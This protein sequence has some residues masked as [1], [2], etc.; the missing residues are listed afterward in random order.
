MRKN[1]LIEKPIPKLLKELAIPAI[2]GVLFNTLYNVVDTFY[3]GLISTEAVAGLSI[4]FFLYFAVVGVGFGFGAAITALIGNSLG[5]KRVFLGSLYAHKG[6]VFVLLLGSILAVLGYI[7]AP[8]VLKSVGAEDNYLPLALEYIRIILFATPFFTA[9]NALN[10]ILVALGDTK[11]YRNMLIVGFF[12]NLILNPLF[13]YGFWILPSLGIKGLALS[14]ALIQVISV[15]YLGKR[16]LNEKMLCFTKVRRYL[17][18]WRIYKH[19]LIQGIPPSMNML[20]MSLGSVITIYYVAIYGYEAVAGYGI[21]FRVEQIM[22]LP[23][24]GLSSAVLSLV[25]NNFGAKLNSRVKETVKLALLVGFLI[26]VIGI[27]LT[28]SI[29]EW[30]ISKFDSNE[31]VIQRAMEYLRI[32]VFAFFGYVVLFISVSALQGIKKP[33]M[34]LYVG[35]YRQI[36][37]KIIIFSLFVFWFKLPYIWLWY[38]LF[39]IIFSS[40]LFL[41]RHTYKALSS[42]K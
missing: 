34:I 4:S 1:E 5:K 32:E 37:G 35:L 41:G 27:F 14:T 18:D 39:F 17:P 20:T 23:A 2:T 29:G 7:F 6:I 12:L 10:A 25:S 16:V 21:A 3:A 40:A 22:L 9:T 28:F 8:W 42:L 19:L 24:L 11:S 26:S 38:G 13:I 15:I 33:K 36:F 30:V 31:I